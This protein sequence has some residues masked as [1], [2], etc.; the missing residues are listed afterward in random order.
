M[1]IGQ[2]I[3]QRR[4]EIGLSADQ[5]ANKLGKHRST[6]YRYESAF[7]EDM[8]I[9]VLE[10][11]ARALDTT[12]AYL[13][14]WT[15]DHGVEPS[16]DWS[17]PLVDA[18]QVAQPPTQKNV[19][20]LLDIPHVKPG[21]VK[22]PAQKT[23]DMVVFDYPA[24]AGLPLYAESDFERIR[25]SADEVPDGADFGIR[26]SGDSMEPTIA[27]G[28]IVWI[29]KQLD[30][31]D[32]EIGVFMLDDSAVCKRARLKKNGQLLLLAS[33]NPRHMPITGTDLIGVRCVGK[34]LL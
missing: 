6:V 22:Q 27:D 20:K 14:G 28:S 15:D 30:I 11:L 16:G 9:S 32:G 19:C 10:P 17:L 31:R 29:H 34:V 12:P 1:N 33:D 7:I 26:I 3:Q 21:D 25:F 23:V 2:R 24:A 8:P 4:N 18:Y 13:M 5:L